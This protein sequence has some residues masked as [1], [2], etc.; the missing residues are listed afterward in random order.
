MA[1]TSVRMKGICG[2]QNLKGGK[3]V[4]ICCGV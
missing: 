4:K 1:K 2:Y 3:K